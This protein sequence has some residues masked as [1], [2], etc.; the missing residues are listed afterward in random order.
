MFLGSLLFCMHS[1][2]MDNSIS[3]TNLVG[4]KYINF[5]NQEPSQSTD[6]QW[7]LLFAPNV[8]KVVNSKIICVNRDQLIN[9]MISVE[10]TYGV[11]KVE[12][13]EV[14]ADSSG[15]I[16]IIHFEVTFEDHTIETVIAI[17][18]CDDKGLIEEMNEVFG[19]K[20]TCD[21]TA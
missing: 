2:T 19:E 1:Q 21:W 12:L 14:I 10:N 9:Q 16:N 13:L 7:E 11:Q 5:L 20:G 8:K 4:N 6:K 17:L 15:R 18:K 3:A